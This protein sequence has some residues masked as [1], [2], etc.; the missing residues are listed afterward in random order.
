ML[1]LIAAIVAGGALMYTLTPKRGTLRIEVASAD[2]RNL[3]RIDG[4]VDGKHECDT[5][6][7]L[8][9]DLDLGEHVIKVFANGYDKPEEQAIKTTSGETRVSIVLR[10]PIRKAN[11]HLGDAPAGAKVVLLGGD[12]RREVSSFPN[13]VKDLDPKVAWTV[14]GTLPGAPELRMPLS[15]AA[16]ETR[17]VLLPFAPTAVDSTP[18]RSSPAPAPRTPP[19]PALRPAAAAAPTPA[20]AAAAA[21][22]PT[23]AAAAAGAAAA[24]PASA[25]ATGPAT[26][27]L[28]SIPASNVVLDGTPIGP[29][30]KLGVSVTSGKHTVLFINSELDLRKKVDF[31]V[32][33]GETKTVAQKLTP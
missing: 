21:A 20:A 5:A 1:G 7:C 23:P 25:E 6:P 3:D 8:I 30:P 28:N 29:T 22:V 11:V 27:N 13:D 31:V 32:K 12:E 24:T 26:L 2:G 18:V 4:M 10:S 17:E 9:K 19:P 16:G 14:V 33:P 15:L